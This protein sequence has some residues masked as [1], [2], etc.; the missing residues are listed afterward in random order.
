VFRSIV[1]DAQGGPFDMTCDL[2][3]FYITGDR[4]VCTARSVHPKYVV[5][6]DLLY[7]AACCC[8]NCKVSTI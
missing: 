4:P 6:K 3:S 8:S 1:R 7:R 5:D 2:P